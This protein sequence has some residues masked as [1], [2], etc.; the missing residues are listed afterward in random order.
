M[1][2]TLFP[3]TGPLRSG[4][5]PEQDGH[6][7]H[8]ETFGNASCPAILL[9]HGGPGD[10]I[11]PRMPRLFDPDRW[12]IVAMDQRGAGRSRP[13]AGESLEALD[14]NTV[15]H[16]LN[17]IERL[18]TLLGV[19]GWHVYGSSWGATLAQ[20][21]AH[22]HAARVSG[23]LLAAVTSTSKFEIDLL[24][25]G[26]GEF[27]PEA[28]EEFRK[29]A[30]EGEPGLGMVAAYYE[31]LVSGD[32][33]SQI[34]A[35]LAWCR[36][37]AAVLTVD[38]R[39]ETPGLFADQRFSL[40]FARVVT[41]YFRNLA[42]LNPPL[43]ERAEALKDIPAVLINSRLDLSTPLSTAW[44]LHRAMPSSKLIVIPGAL[45][46]TLYGP[47]SEAVIDAGNRFASGNAKR[48]KSC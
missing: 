16:L 1:A 40:G 29:G 31:R 13:H 27:L 11:S 41:H 17:D 43:L 38:P 35:A 37:E 21:Y 4:Y 28:F 44:K 48:T 5:L 10:G 6:S 18:R 20:A 45:H 26:A 47:L 42:G 39:A 2:T 36:W 34:A 8:W 23:L 19:D 33:S 14:A 46:G 32:P 22:A 30:P 9:L 25:G 24:Y 15:A 3:E 12:H 7:V